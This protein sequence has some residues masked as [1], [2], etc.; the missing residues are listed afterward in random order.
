MGLGKTVQMIAL[1][2]S[3]PPTTAVPCAPSE[4][5]GD[6][7]GDS[8]SDD[9]IYIADDD[10]GVVD[11]RSSGNVSEFSSSDSSDD[12]SESESNSDSSDDEQRHQRAKRAHERGQRRRQRKLVRRSKVASRRSKAVPENSSWSRRVCV[13]LMDICLC[14]FFFFFFA[15]GLSLSLSLYYCL[16]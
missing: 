14:V 6:N 8:P 10:D 1:I 11:M 2:V 3:N 13:K 12:E 9:E 5:S 7:S 4:C 16:L 15:M